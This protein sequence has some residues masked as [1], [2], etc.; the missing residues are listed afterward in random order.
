MGKNI[1][2]KSDA[3][4]TNYRCITGIIILSSAVTISVLIDF[5]V[6]KTITYNSDNR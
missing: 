4:Y 2:F 5:S 6:N 1:K 3:F